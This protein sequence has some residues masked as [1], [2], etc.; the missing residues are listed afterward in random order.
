MSIVIGGK[1]IDTPFESV[2]WLDDAKVAPRVTDYGARLR[3]PRIICL[4]TVHGKLGPVR[5]GFKASDRAA[6]YA[7]YQTRTS[8]AVSWDATLDT[9]GTLIWQ[10]DPLERF[11]WHA[12]AINPVSIGIEC[13]QD[14]DGA[15]YDGQLQTLVRV[16]DLL[17]GVLGIQRQMPWIGSG[18]PRGVRPRLDEHGPAKG[19]NWVGMCA[20]FMVTTSRGLGD[21]LPPFEYFARAG[22]EKFDYDAGS[23]LATWKIRQR[24][25]GMPPSEQDGIA[26]TKTRAA[27]AAS[28]RLLG[29]WTA[30]PGD[31]LLTVAT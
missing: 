27:L 17:T 6:V 28:G 26:L 31:E 23:D 16:A 2:C 22:Y 13:I 21:T 7:R 19:A 11:C 29:Q 10:N 5:P 9:D 1:R 3:R 25:A 8:R 15:L 20:H 24:A 12:T 4:H 18:V 14:D 30:R